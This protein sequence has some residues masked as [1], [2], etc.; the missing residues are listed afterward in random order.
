MTHELDPVEHWIAGDSKTFENTVEEDGSARD[1][2]G[3]T[4][5]WYLFPMGASTTDTSN[6]DFSHNDSGVTVNRVDDSNGRFNVE[7]NEDV[8]TSGG[9]YI[10]RVI[11]DPTS[12]TK[13]T[14]TGL[15]Y[16]TP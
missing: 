3:D 2:T 5:E 11:V 12:S 8:V 9:N 1:I 7:V 4:L 10:Q 16:I 6:A 13:Q 14:W 15:V